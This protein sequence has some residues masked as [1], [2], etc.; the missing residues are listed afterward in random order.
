[1]KEKVKKNSKKKLS[2]YFLHEMFT[3]QKHIMEKNEKVAFQFGFRW[4][5]PKKT[6]RKNMTIDIRFC[7]LEETFNS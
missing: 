5:C 3:N 1:M 7:G 6:E 4:G 2:R